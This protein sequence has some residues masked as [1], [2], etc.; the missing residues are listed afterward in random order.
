[1]E[2]SQPHRNCSLRGAPVRSMCERVRRTRVWIGLIPEVHSCDET[3][4]HSK[5][6]NNLAIRKHITLKALYEL[7]HPDTGLAPVFLGHCKRFNM[8]IELTPLSLP[9][10]ADLFFSD[11]FS[12]LGSLGPAHVLRHQC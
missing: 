12:A 8:G 10:G 4:V 5:H 7:V 6:V 1:M 11:N 9:I 3:T 2:G